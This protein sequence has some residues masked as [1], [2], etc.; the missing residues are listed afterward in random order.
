MEIYAVT[1]GTHDV[2]YLKYFALKSKAELYK[3]ELER[4][5]T[6]SEWQMSEEYTRACKALNEFRNALQVKY[7]KMP[8][9]RTADENT[10]WQDLCSAVYGETRSTDDYDIKEI[11]VHF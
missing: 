7:P 2:V 1:T 9:S 10:Q 11:T 8:N 5:M 4:R 3:Q 6:I